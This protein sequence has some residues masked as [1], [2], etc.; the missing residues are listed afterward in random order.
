MSSIITVLVIRGT[1]S[2]GHIRVD[3]ENLVTDTVTHI[4]PFASAEDAAEALGEFVRNTFLDALQKHALQRSQTG[5]V[6]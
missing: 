4:P 2:N 1:E 6:Q 5:G 3:V